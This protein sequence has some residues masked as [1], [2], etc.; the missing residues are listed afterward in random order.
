[1]RSTGDASECLN[2]VTR[3]LRV[4]V[5]PSLRINQFF[6]KFLA[7][8]WLRKLNGEKKQTYRHQQKGKSNGFHSS[9]LE[10]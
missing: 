6:G 1:V 4:A 3:R 5:D 9:A 7:T 2:K 8:F 10:E